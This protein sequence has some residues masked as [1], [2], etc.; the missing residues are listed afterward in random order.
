MSEIL[1]NR[2]EIV[3]LYDATDCNPNGDPLNENRPRI[4]EEAE[5]N[6][7]TDVRLKRTVRDYLNDFLDQEIFI[8]EEKTDKGEQ[9]TRTR[10]LGEFLTKNRDR[11]PNWELSE[12]ELEDI[13]DS[14]IQNKIGEL[15]VDELEKALLKNYV[16][17]RL[18]G[19]TIAVKQGTITKTGPVQF[20][21]GRSLHKVEPKFIK[22]T[23][24]MPST[25]KRAVGTFTEAYILPYSLICFY[26]IANENAA[27]STGLRKDDIDLLLEGL[28]KGTKNLITRS[29]FGQVPR[30]LLQIEYEEENYHIGELDK[31]IKIKNDKDDKELRSIKDVSIDLTE[32]VNKIEEEKERIS[33]IH[34]KADERAVFECNG[35]EIPGS[36]LAEAFPESVEAVELD[37]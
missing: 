13:E 2:S 19:A 33:K 1:E 30:L 23:T 17:L 4:D 6:L 29:K 37:L 27:K 12:D 21:F 31:Y 22:G 20:K 18:F 8:K 10:R 28:W 34:Y 32:L 5:I 15:G 25:E 7:V 36:R 14:E 24:V 3:F 26:G 16:D 35:E 11:F 9:K